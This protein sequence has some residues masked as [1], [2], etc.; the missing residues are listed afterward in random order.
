MLLLLVNGSLKAC[1][2]AQL[3][4]VIRHIHW[5]VIF[6]LVARPYYWVL[7]L[8]AYANPPTSRL[9]DCLEHPLALSTRAHVRLFAWKLGGFCLFLEGL[10]CV[11]TTFGFFILTFIQLY[12]LFFMEELLLYA[13]WCFSLSTWRSPLH[14]GYNHF[15]EIRHY[16]ER[17]TQLPS[18]Y[19]S[20]SSIF[21]LSSSESEPIA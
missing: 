19:P 1:G 15:I 3:F 21:H 6:I 12:T 18:Y 10:Q 11:C 5:A 20:P 2:C 4:V 16:T 8:H 9:Q 13:A 17:K 14:Y 7:S